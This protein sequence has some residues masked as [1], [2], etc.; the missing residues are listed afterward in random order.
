MKYGG[1]DR[2]F[3]ARSDFA[4]GQRNSHQLIDFTCGALPR[5]LAVMDDFGH[6]PV[7]KAG[8]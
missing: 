3:S 7:A 4:Q 1:E 2:A 8:L 5:R 6:L